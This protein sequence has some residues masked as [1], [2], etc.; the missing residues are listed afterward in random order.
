M[1]IRASTIVGMVGGGGSGM[2]LLS[3]L[4][5]FKYSQSAG[6][7]FVI[8]SIVILVDSMTSM[9]RKKVMNR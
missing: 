3:Y 4:K 2:I 8:A 6:I 5:E 9:L 1:N 7:I